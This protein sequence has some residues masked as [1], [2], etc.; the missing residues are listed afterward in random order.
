MRITSVNLQNV[1]VK[2][3]KRELGFKMLSKH[4]RSWKL[5]SNYTKEGEELKSKE[6]QGKIHP[7]WRVGF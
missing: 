7:K 1:I 6:R 5:K 3:R 2:I 4:K